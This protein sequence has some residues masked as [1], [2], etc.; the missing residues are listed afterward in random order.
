M[1][2]SPTGKG[3]LENLP[4]RLEAEIQKLLSP[5]EAVLLKIKGAFKEGLI[6]TDRR[7]IIL[8]SGFMTG[9]AF[10]SEVY[11][12][13]YGNIAGVQVTFHLMSGYFELNAGGMQN[14]RK[15]YWSSD[16]KSDPSKAPNCVSLNNKKLVEKFRHACS[17]ILTKIDESRHGEAVAPEPA[18]VSIPEQISQLASLRDQGI[19]SSEEFEA[20]KDLLNRM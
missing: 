12:Q 3:L 1:A 20:K 5:D 8:K 19:L 2:E 9:Q 16:P 18:T 13:P 14:V 10:G 17:F 15:R 6:C 7:V 11:Q 4:G